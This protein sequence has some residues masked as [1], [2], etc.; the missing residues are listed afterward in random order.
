MGPSRFDVSSKNFDVTIIMLGIIQVL[1]QWNR[2][3]IQLISFDKKKVQNQHTDTAPTIEKLEWF[4]LF[5]IRCVCRG[6]TVAGAAKYGA[7][8]K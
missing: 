1:E 6:G 3:V 4:T 7:Q 2:S 8:I 5:A